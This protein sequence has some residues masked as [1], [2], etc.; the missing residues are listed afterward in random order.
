MQEPFAV[1]AD[2]FFFFF[3]NC[4]YRTV[5]GFSVSNNTCSLLCIRL[6]HGSHVFIC[7]HVGWLILQSPAKIH[8]IA[9][10]RKPNYSSLCDWLTLLLETSVR[11]P[12]VQQ[13]TLIREGDVGLIMLYL[14]V[15]ENYKLYAFL[16]LKDYVCGMFAFIWQQ[17]NQ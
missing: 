16:N 17:L 5:I 6:S 8:I 14:F 13:F 7:C 2:F 9:V 10:V 12:T 3:F 15:C 1:C 4:V 11:L